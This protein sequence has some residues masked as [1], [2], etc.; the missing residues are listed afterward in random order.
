[1]KTYRYYIYLSDWLEYKHT[2]LREAYIGSKYQFTI[3]RSWAGF[4]ER[5]DNIRSQRQTTMLA[6]L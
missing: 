3:T 2:G 5:L 4:N 6:V 1:M